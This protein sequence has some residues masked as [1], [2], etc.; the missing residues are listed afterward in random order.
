MRA[1]IVSLVA[2]SVL[3]FAGSAFA[4]DP[5]TPDEITLKLGQKNLVICKSCHSLAQGERAKIG[6]N[7][8]GV[9]GSKAGSKEGF[10]YSD[11]M[12]NSGI[13]WDEAKLDEYLA[14]PK[15]FMPGN[16]MVFVGVRKE[17]ERKALIAVLK[18]ETGADN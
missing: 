11:V 2:A 9:F 3:G 14:K 4:A 15:E 18:R 16:K 12:K 8:W 13:V 10:N 17:D 7:L 1:F 6:P 5:A